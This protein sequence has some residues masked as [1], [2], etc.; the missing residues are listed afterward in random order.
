M[1]TRKTWVTI[2]I[3]ALIALF[4]GIALTIGKIKDI[5]ISEQRIKEKIAEKIPFRA[6]KLRTV[7]LIDRLD[8]NLDN[9]LINLSFDVKLYGFTKEVKIT[10]KAN[11]NLVY[12][13]HGGSFHFRHQNL[14]FLEL[15]VAGFEKSKM[16]EE[17][18]SAAVEMAVGLYLN[19]FPVYR[20]PDDF[21][22]KVMKIALESVE[23]RDRTI[24]AHLSFWQLTK[25]VLIYSLLFVL[26]VPVAFGFIMNAHW[27]SFLILGLG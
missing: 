22:G 17:L 3:S 20:L 6:Q 7:V 11:G 10:A 2:S 9:N 13:S 4:S 8:F 19:I 15:G 16:K 23:I 26:M 21:K 27:T 12:N 14:E 24:I 25:T 18:I 5:S 1:F